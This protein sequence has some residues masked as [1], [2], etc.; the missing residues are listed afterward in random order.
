M[1]IAVALLGLMCG[2]FV[3]A[4]V[5]RVHEQ[6][7]IKKGSK[8]AWKRRL[9]I[10]HGRSMCPHCKHELAAIDLIPVLSWL[11]LSGKCRYCKHPIGVQYPIVE[12]LVMAL[13]AVSYVF[14]PYELTGSGI[15]YLV[16][17]LIA[18]VILAALAVY[19]LRWMLL[20]NRLVFPLTGLGVANAVIAVVQV[21]R[22][23][24]VLMIAGAVLVAGGI[25]YVLYQVSSGNW[26]GG[27]DVKLGYAIGLLLLDPWLAMLMLFLASVLGCLVALPFLAAK[28]ASL[29]S[30]IPFGPYLILATIIVKLFG[31]QMIQ[32][33]TQLVIG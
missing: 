14:W 29:V 24:Q 3:N 27:G 25:F 1:L 23:S 21:P 4:L 28:R 10:V 18:L 30:K 17:W 22:L 31:E 12:L 15:A 26:I 16:I 5:W 7:S 19:D 9:S 33:Y 8:V 13:F 20:P 32:A 11:S 2:S 6:A